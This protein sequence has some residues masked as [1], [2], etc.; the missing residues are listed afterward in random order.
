MPHAGLCR[1]PRRH[2]RL[3]QNYPPVPATDCAGPETPGLPPLSPAWPQS[4]S[5]PPT[6]Y[7]LGPPHEGCHKHSH[8]LWTQRY[9]FVCIQVPRGRAPGHQQDDGLGPRFR[10]FRTTE[11]GPVGVYQE[12]LHRLGRLRDEGNRDP[13]RS[14]RFLVCHGLFHGVLEVP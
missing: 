12:P 2:Q 4:A 7:E 1:K 8:V 11:D 10:D 13:T 3:T 14:R 5:L 6:A 9:R